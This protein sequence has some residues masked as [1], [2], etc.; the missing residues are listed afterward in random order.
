MDTRTAVLTVRVW[1]W[2]FRHSLHTNVVIGTKSGLVLRSVRRPGTYALTFGLWGNVEPF[3]R[4]VQA[5][6][7][8][9]GRKCEIKARSAL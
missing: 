9:T 1:L 2:A 8:P 4:V 7:R 5:E 3:A 6:R